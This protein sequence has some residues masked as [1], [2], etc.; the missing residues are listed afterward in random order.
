MKIVELGN[1]N[2]QIEEKLGISRER[3]RKQRHMHDYL[4]YMDHS[5]QILQRSRPKIELIT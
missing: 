1:G 4:H 2:D 5:P 3:N